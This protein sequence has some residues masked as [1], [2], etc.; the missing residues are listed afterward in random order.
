MNPKT[1]GPARWPT[2]AYRVTPA[3]VLLPDESAT[4]ARWVLS[5]EWPSKMAPRAGSEVRGDPA[6][7]ETSGEYLV[8]VLSM[9]SWHGESEGRSVA[10][11]RCP[12]ARCSA[13]YVS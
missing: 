3:V 1:V 10:I 7:G 11:P 4:S 5:A 6:R 9:N 8:K 12:S 2:L 13:V